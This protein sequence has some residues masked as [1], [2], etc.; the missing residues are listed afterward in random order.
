M[1]RCELNVRQGASFLYTLPEI[2]TQFPLHTCTIH[3]DLI[4]KGNLAT[5]VLYAGARRPS[6]GMSRV[7]MYVRRGVFGQ[8]ERVS[9]GIG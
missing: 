1:W 9:G 2:L 3:Q 4:I 7:K 8:V 5:K 6:V